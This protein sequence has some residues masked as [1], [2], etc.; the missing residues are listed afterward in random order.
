ML[1]AKPI[2]YMISGCKLSKQGSC[3]IH[4]PSFLQHRIQK[5]DSVFSQRTSCQNQHAWG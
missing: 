2:S 4:H 5:L 1:E 3:L